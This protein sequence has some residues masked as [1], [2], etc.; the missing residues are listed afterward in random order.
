MNKTRTLLFVAWAACSMHAM[1]QRLTLDECLAMAYENNPQLRSEL[2][3]IEKNQ[4][5]IGTAFD[6]P[7]TEIEL[8]QDATSG[9]SM[10]NG[11]TFS[12]EF[13]FPTL[14]IAKRKVL[15]TDY[16]VAKD[17]YHVQKNEL[18]GNIVSTYHSLLFVKH[19]VKAL[20]RLSANYATFARIA[21]ARF[22][23]GESSRLETMNADRLCAKSDVELRN[24]KA[25]WKSLCLRLMSL[26]GSEEWIEPADDALPVLDTQEVTD[27][28]L[29]AL[30]YKGKWLESEL[31]RSQQSLGMA[32][33]EFMPGLFVAATTQLLIKDFNPYHIERPR[34]EQGNFMGF[35]VGITIP[36]FFGAKRARLLAAKR[37][38]EMAKLRIEDANLQMKQAYADAQ[39]EFQAAAENLRYYEER[40]LQQA[41]EMARLAQVSY[42]LGDIDYMEYMQNVETASALHIE[43]LESIERYNQSIIKLQ[44]IKGIL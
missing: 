7:N 41:N 32:K 9:G 22:E 36:L 23:A 12:Q 37:D 13:D 1:A 11:V 31:L 20:E 14:Y 38:V 42:E 35:Q 8:S 15:K 33:Q 16:L 26:T 44:T 18:C 29:P 21:H 39:N 17:Y 3:N 5:L 34:F 28:L 25:E 10:E 19:K 2:K 40:G 24:A 43:Y 6:A 4:L 27:E 30:T